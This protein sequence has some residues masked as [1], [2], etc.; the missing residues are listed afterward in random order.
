[1]VKQ[2]NT[3]YNEKVGLISRLGVFKRERKEKT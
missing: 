3:N 2:S 1:L